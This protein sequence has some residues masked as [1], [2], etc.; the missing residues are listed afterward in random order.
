VG[1][2]ILVQREGAE[3]AEAPP[4]PLVAVPNVTAHQSTANVPIT[5]LL[6]DGPLLLS[7]NVAIKGLK[8]RRKRI[9]FL[10]AYIC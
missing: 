4:I 2:Y 1:C 8:I 5:G 3:R 9:R 10:T 7:F 6:Y